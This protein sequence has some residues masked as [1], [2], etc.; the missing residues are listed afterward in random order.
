MRLGNLSNII[1]LNCEQIIPKIAEK[2]H[3]S[4]RRQTFQR[5]SITM[6]IVAVLSHLVPLERCV[7][8]NANG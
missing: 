1:N 4:Q 3:K 5:Q 6:Q 7:S 2:V 8:V